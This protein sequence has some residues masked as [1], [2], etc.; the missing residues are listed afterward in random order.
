MSDANLRL[1]RKLS[2]SLDLTD[3]DCLALYDIMENRKLADGEFLFQ[4]GEVDH[5]LYA[6]AKGRLE[7]VTDT[8]GGEH[9]GLQTFKAG[10]VVGELGFL[11]GTGHS[12]GMMSI[13]ESEV[14]AMNRERFE[15]LLD[16]NPQLVYGVMRGI[17]RTVHAILRRMNLQYTEMNSYISKQHGRY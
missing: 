12:A 10:D 13:G 8:G 5:T 4:E 11:D 1:I 3:E 15:S 16:D 17:V 7:A 2:I 9:I 6:I 14:L